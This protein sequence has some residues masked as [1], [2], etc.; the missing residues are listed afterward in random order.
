M[1]K[2]QKSTNFLFILNFILYCGH[3]IIFLLGSIVEN[4]IGIFWDQVFYKI[5]IIFFSFFDIHINL[6]IVM[7]IVHFFKPVFVLINTPFSAK[8]E[9]YIVCYYYLF[10]FVFQSLL[11]M[12]ICIPE[13]T[14]HSHNYLYIFRLTDQLYLKE[15][16]HPLFLYL[17]LPEDF[18]FLFV[19]SWLWKTS[20]VFD[21]S[22]C[23]L[24]L[25]FVVYLLDSDL[26][27]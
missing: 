11:F 18:S 25:L 21:M 26:Y 3:S 14:D 22:L 9:D 17:M 16:Q 6:F 13:F 10:A 4:L 19:I 8:N 1:P 20:L 27:T 12:A 15:Y 24:P 23:I 5:L 2:M 7:K